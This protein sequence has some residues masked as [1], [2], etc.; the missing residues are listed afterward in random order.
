MLR[1]WLSTYCPHFARAVKACLTG[2]AVTHHSK[3]PSLRPPWL[4]RIA[5]SGPDRLASRLRFGVQIGNV[6]DAARNV[7][8]SKADSLTQARCSLKQKGKQNCTDY[9]CL[10]VC[11]TPSSAISR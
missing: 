2:L 3:L 6:N 1:L 9:G 4:I 8:G 11:M 10:E 5:K 7:E